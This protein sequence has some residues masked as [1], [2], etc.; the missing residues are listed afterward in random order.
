M[1]LKSF[2]KGVMPNR[3]L[4]WTRNLI[5]LIRIKSIHAAVREQKLLPIYHRLSAIVPS[6]TH[7]YS[8]FD[9]DTEYLVT[10]VRTMHAFQIFPVNKALQL[11]DCSVEGTISIVDIG[12][13]AGTHIQYIKGLHE[14]RDLQRLGINIDDEAVKRIKQKGLEAKGGP[15]SYSA[16]SKTQCKS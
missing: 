5:E 1:G 2:L 8:S 3:V 11:I 7:Q 4:L 9:L 13:S 16:K 10:K 14:D 12:D 6:I 15:V